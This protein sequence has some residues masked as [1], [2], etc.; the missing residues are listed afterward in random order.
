MSN[1]TKSREMEVKYH[2]PPETDRTA[3]HHSNVHCWYG[4]ELKGAVLHSWGEMELS[5]NFR[6]VV[7]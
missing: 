7:C 4:C 6:E 5:Q 1:L 3:S 2:F